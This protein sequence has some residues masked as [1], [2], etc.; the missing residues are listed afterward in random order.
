MLRLWL[1]AGL[2]TGIVLTL[3]ALVLSQADDKKSA[4]G[5]DGFKVIFD[6]KT[7]DGWKASEKKD[8]W[9][10]EDGAFVAHGERS[11]LFYVGD[12]K[13][14]KDFELK[15]DVWTEP[16]AN[17][18][19]Y[20]HTKFQD[21]GWPKFGFEV[22]VNNTG[23]DPK[24]TGSLYAIKNLDASPA[25][26]KEWYTNHIIVKSKVVT[27][28]I[29]DKEVLSYTEPADAKAGKDFSRKLD[30]GTFALQ[31]HD[32]K[33]IVKYKNIKVKRTE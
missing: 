14:F 11:H 4:A 16:K 1:F 7:F 8:T 27:I 21:D 26:D 15:V 31:A 5:D 33:S 6:G 24:K 3:P 22:Q 13:P 17:G 32:P 18:G 28:K 30:G 12:E 20:F 2:L 19:I 25:K 23:G 10:I 9:K 29:N